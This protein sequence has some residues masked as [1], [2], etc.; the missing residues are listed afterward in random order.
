MIM[1]DEG[2]SRLQSRNKQ[3]DIEVHK[4]RGKGIEQKGFENPAPF[5]MILNTKRG[6]HN[7]VI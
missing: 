3:N 7:E 2:Y 6:Q 1:R 5:Y 4:K